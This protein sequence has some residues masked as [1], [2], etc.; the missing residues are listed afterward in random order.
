MAD[1]AESIT[2]AIHNAF[3]NAQ[4]LTCWAHVQRAYSK[5]LLHIKNKEIEKKLSDDLYLLQ[6][7]YSKRTFEIGYALLRRNYQTL[8]ETNEQV[9][10]FFEYFENEWIDSLQNAWYEGAG[11][12]VPSTNNALESF[13]RVIKANHTLRERFSL[14]VFLSK[15]VEMLQS[16]SIDRSSS[17]KFY[18]LPEISTELWEASDEYIDSKPQVKYLT[19]E[20]VYLLLNATQDKSN[21]E[22]FVESSEC[23]L[24][25]E[26]LTSCFGSFSDF[27]LLNRLVKRVSLN[28]SC[29]QLSKCSC[30]TFFKQFICKHIVFLAVK[31][32]LTEINYNFK[33]VGK[34]NKRG[35][36]RKA[37]KALLKM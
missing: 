32:N 20:N 11:T 37:T 29:W 23:S 22:K 33:R 19:N 18:P 31:R 17:K 26:D 2:I 10:L 5:R 35:A 15:L 28:S 34:K 3:P 21:F 9:K 14:S 4:R 25:C 27:F 24:E 6:E 36:K 1:A 13:N 30:R 12:H 7:S 8:I 16:W